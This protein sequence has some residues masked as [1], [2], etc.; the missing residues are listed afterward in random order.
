MDEKRLEKAKEVVSHHKN[1]FEMDFDL[2][3]K[4]GEP[5]GGVTAWS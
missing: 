3:R 2:L 5:N 1:L 4:E